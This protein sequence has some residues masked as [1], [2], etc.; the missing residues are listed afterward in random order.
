[1]DIEATETPMPGRRKNGGTSAGQDA[2][3]RNKSRL[4]C[5]VPTCNTPG[6]VTDD[7]HQVT[8]HKL[9]I[10]DKERLRAWIVKIRRDVGPNFK[11][12][13]HTRICSRH[14]D[15]SDFRVTFKGKRFLK[16]NAT[17]KKFSWTKPVKSRADRVTTGACLVQMPAIADNENTLEVPSTTQDISPNEGIIQ[18]LNDRIQE[19]QSRLTKEEARSNILEKERNHV[20]GVLTEQLDKTNQSHFN[21]H[22]F[23]DNDSDVCFY[24][25][26]PTYNSLCICFRFL[27]SE[28]CLQVGHKKDTKLSHM[29]QFTLTLLRL[30]LGLFEKDLAWRFNISQ[31]SVNRIFKLWVN[32][33]YL[34]LGSVNIWPSQE[35]IRRTMPE[36]MK[37]KF[38]YLEWIIDAFEIQTQRPASLML[39][40]QSYSSYKSRNTVKGL[41]A[42]TPSGQVGFVSQLYTGN[43]SD[44]ELVK[45]S[46]FLSMPH[47][48]GAMWLVDK[49]FQIQDL[50]DKLEVT[51][52]MPAFVGK[53]DQLTAEEVFQTQSIASERIHIERVINKIKKFHFFDRQIPIST[54][55]LVNQA[56]AVCSLL[57]H[58]QNPVISA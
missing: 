16:E 13:E 58:F 23:K 17:P 21:I 42:C 19:L 12:T 52:N 3:K 43:I 27:N 40:S 35:Q 10:R 51:V 49:G 47:N 22:S 41:V 24:T 18:K 44:R 15:Q 34:R 28:K 33:M 5:C 14:F 55:G 54:M 38:P 48:K 6:Y 31:S 45:R 20:R 9:P 53:K 32:F 57:T 30:R 2:G 29:D 4:S 39:Q 50:A 8:F 7:G 1:M 56:W 11:V 46:G 37:S 36:S 26:F 25:G